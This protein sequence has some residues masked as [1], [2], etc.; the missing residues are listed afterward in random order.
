MEKKKD[1][2]KIKKKKLFSFAK[3]NKYFIFPFLSPI[4]CFLGNFFLELIYNDEG[5]N[6]KEFLIAI[7]TSLSYIGGG[8]LYFISWIR[9][10]TE[11]SR[12]EALEHLE[13]KE[14]NPSSIRYIYNDGLKKN[15]LH[16]FFILLIMSILLVFSTVASIYALEKNVFEE[17]LYFLFF[18]PLFSKII[19]KLDIFSHQIL[20]LLIAFIGL[21]LLFIP[22]ILI[23]EKDDI[24]INILIFVSSI[25][26]SL[27]L[28]LCR[29]LTQNYYMSPYL[30]ILFIGIYS[31]LITL[32][33]YIIYSLIKYHSLSYIIDTFN[34]KNIELDGTMLGLYCFLSL[35]FASILQILS[36]LV[37]YYFSPT[38]FAVT[39][40][41]SPFL[42]WIVYCIQNGESGRNI[43][44]NCIGYFVVF[45]SSLIYNEI[46]I[47]NFYG[48]NENVKKCIEER[49]KEELI[50]IRMSESQIETQN[51][52]DPDESFD[53]ENEG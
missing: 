21:I 46:I 17:R 33:G 4:F 47:C 29:L 7:I 41:I 45:F 15:K 48:L 37:I 14:R 36:I 28:V 35:F 51:N 13:R 10:R 30:C 50:E 16:I 8:I 19:L 27:V 1:K 25:G 6:N 52:K 22:V 9:T 42:S 23:I 3:L 43:A 2:N 5:I 44:F 12:D 20:S 31:T 18:I 32:I 11:E 34:F 40:I 53:T 26:F 38:L 49:Q 39:D 24:L